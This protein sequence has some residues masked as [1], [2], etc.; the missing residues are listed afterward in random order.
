[1]ISERIKEIREYFSQMS[2]DTDFDLES[3][4]DYLLDLVIEIADEFE[5]E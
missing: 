1:M 2:D 3:A 4:K 5:E